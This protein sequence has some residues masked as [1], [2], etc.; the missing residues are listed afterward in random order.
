MWNVWNFRN[1]SMLKRTIKNGLRNRHVNYRASHMSWLNIMISMKCQKQWLHL[2]NKRLNG[3]VTLKIDDLQHKVK[4]DDDGVDWKSIWVTPNRSNDKKS[5]LVDDDD[6]WVGC[7]CWWFI[8]PCVP[9]FCAR[10]AQKRRTA[11]GD[12]ASSHKLHCILVFCA[13]QECPNPIFWS[14]MH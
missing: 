2:E 7:P 5:G 9:V 13:Y 3:V 10:R 12:L 11:C 8:C 6:G 4:L 1:M 14:K